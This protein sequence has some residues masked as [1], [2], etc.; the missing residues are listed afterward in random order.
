MSKLK[1]V[2]KAPAPIKADDII[3]LALN[4]DTGEIMLSVLGWLVQIN[5]PTEED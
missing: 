4:I 5:I 1:R 2:K 3:A